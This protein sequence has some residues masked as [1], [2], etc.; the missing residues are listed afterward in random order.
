MKIIIFKWFAHL[1]KNL[2][3]KKLDFNLNI[4][5]YKNQLSFNIMKS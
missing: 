3:I 2:I 5:S 1:K 4:N